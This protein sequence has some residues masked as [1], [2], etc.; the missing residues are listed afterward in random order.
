MTLT[1]STTSIDQASPLRTCRPNLYGE[2]KFPQK[3]Q[4]RWAKSVFAQASVTPTIIRLRAGVHS[5]P[6]ARFDITSAEKRRNK[7]GPRAKQNAPC[8]SLGPPKG[9]NKLWTGAKFMSPSSL[10]RV[11][12]G[13]EEL[14]CVAMVEDF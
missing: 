3:Q 14:A 6:D 8:D 11:S 9:A 10:G 4:E 7:R 1:T 5:T 13:G 2:I 12:P